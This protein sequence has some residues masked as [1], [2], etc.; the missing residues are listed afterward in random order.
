ME[1]GDDRTRAAVAPDHNQVE[2]A[3]ARNRAEF[4]ARNRVEAHARN[5]M[6]ARA[7]NRMKVRAR[8]EAVASGHVARL[9]TR[10]T[11]VR[12]PATGLLF[13][14]A[15]LSPQWATLAG[16]M[17]NADG[18]ISGPLSHLDGEISS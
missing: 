5:R 9:R 14:G 12:K 6:K 18:S 17:G 11:R 2:A 8:N 4:R 7:R 15:S 16:T 13:E 1:A 10:S 3:H